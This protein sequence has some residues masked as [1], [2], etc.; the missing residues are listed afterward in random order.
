MLQ[1]ELTQ[2]TKNKQPRRKWHSICRDNLYFDQ[3]CYQI[4]AYAICFQQKCTLST[5]TQQP[6]NGKLSADTD[7]TAL[8]FA[9][10]FG[11]NILAPSD[12]PDGA[13]ANELATANSRKDVLG[14]DV[15]EMVE[16][17]QAKPGFQHPASPV[18]GKALTAVGQEEQGALQ[19]A[20][21][22]KT[23]F[24][25][26]P[27]RIIANPLG[28][29]DILFRPEFGA[30][31]HSKGMTGSAAQSTMM[32]MVSLAYDE[33]SS[34]PGN[35][36]TPRLSAAS[37]TEKQII[38]N[39]LPMPLSPARVAPLPQQ[40]TAKLRDDPRAFANKLLQKIEPVSVTAEVITA[41]TPKLGISVAAA[42][43]GMDS[44][45][46]EAGRTIMS[47]VGQVVGQGGQQ[48]SQQNAGQS[49][50]GSSYNTGATS[51]AFNENMLEMLD[52]AQDNW[53]EMLLNRVK[54]GLASGKEKLEFLLNPRNL[55]KMKVTLG[56][57][58]DRTTVQVT[59][60]TAA[61]AKLIVES[62]RALGAIDGCVRFEIGSA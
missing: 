40:F 55:G 14:A 7:Q 29:A 57:Q 15:D 46:N 31:G 9:A 6:A 61:A 45:A 34:K 18:K 37:L 51:Q 3:N 23:E 2:K 1:S 30:M 59:T 10:L 4:S 38:N 17:Q 36:T 58:N 50:S 33:Q 62:R 27:E 54:T 52:M 21:L 16:L 8:L 19:G 41:G 5:V 12:G 13:I 25:N 53:T 11:A 48:N 39:G 20:G 24:L 56:V 47:L 49:S 22:T 26:E 35:V 60:E 28:A 42:T 44:F 43:G 32:Q